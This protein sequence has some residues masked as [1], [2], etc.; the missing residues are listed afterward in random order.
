MS[1]KHEKEQAAQAV[2]ETEQT[3]PENAETAGSQP[4][5][6]KEP[7][8]EEK[9]QAELNEL[10]DRYLRTLAEYDNY[11][12][13]TAKEKEA[14][15][16]EAK[17]NTIAAVLPVLDSFERA[18]EAPCSDEDFKRGL[19][20]I[21]KA[22]DEVLQKQGVEAFGQVGEEFDPNQHSA[23]AHQED[24][25]VGENCIAEVFQKGYRMGD[26]ILRYAMVKVA[27]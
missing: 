9:L 8:P 23:V 20:L 16:P 12:K 2:P 10:N 19:E 24:D 25:S 6:A 21:R 1:N 17:A 11:R 13:R 4:E 7:T 26:R 3:A 14:I 5:A 18:M 27:N 22:F 15:Y